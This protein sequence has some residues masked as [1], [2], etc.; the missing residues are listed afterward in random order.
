MESDGCFPEVHEILTDVEYF[1]KVGFDDRLLSTFNIYEKDGTYYWPINSRQGYIQEG[2]FRPQDL[3]KETRL[4]WAIIYERYA[5]APGTIFINFGDLLLYIPVVDRRRWKEH[6][7]EI[8]FPPG[9]AEKLLFYENEK[10]LKDVFEDWNKHAEGSNLPWFTSQEYEQVFHDL[11][12][13]K[14]Y[15]TEND[16]WRDLS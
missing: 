2:R 14:L 9:N 5:D 11:Q 16:L 12:H 3:D 15:D 13:L 6:F 7:K 8:R 1:S 4:E 10:E